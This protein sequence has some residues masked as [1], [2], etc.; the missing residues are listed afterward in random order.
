MLK[1]KENAGRF[2]QASTELHLL[3]LHKPSQYHVCMSIQYERYN[4]T[5]SNAAAAVTPAMFAEI[6]KYYETRRQSPRG[7]GRRDRQAGTN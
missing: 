7:S 1:Q 4:S 5:V 6:Y 3:T 2:Q